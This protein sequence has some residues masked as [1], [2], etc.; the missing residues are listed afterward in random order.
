MGIRFTINK[1]LSETDV[2]KFYTLKQKFNPVSDII[3]VIS[4]NFKQTIKYV[5]KKYDKSYTILQNEIK[6]SIIVVKEDFIEKYIV[7]ENLDDLTNSV[8]KFKRY[9]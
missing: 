8:Y 9:L 4:K 6:K 2:I 5:K 1:K 3:G 7:L